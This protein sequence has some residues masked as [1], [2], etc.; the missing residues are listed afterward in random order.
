MP[1]LYS[2]TDAEYNQI[3]AERVRIQSVMI[4]ANK[5]YQYYTGV[6]LA[7]NNPF[8]HSVQI[9]P[10]LYRFV[11]KIVSVDVGFMGA[12]LL[13]DIP[14]H[15]EYAMEFKIDHRTNGL[16]VNCITK[17]EYDLCVL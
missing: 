17:G 3:E 14:E 4:R 7:I 15:S 9:Y 1:Y 2:I 5:F 10:A 6:K 13:V 12:R 8:A 16:V 11:A